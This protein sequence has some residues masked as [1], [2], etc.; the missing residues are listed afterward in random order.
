MRRISL[1][2]LFFA[3]VAVI[4]ASLVVSLVAQPNYPDAFYHFNAANRLVSG[5]GLTDTYLWTYLAAPENLPAPSHLYWMPLTSLTAAVGMWLFNAPGNYAAAQ[6]PLT[7]MLIGIIYVGYWLGQKLG[8]TRRHAWVAGLLTLF[9]GFFVRFWG[10]T[11][12]FAPYALIGSLCLVAISLGQST[13]RKWLWFGI[14]GALAGLGHL[15]RVDGLLLLLVGGVVVLWPDS[16]SSWRERIIT[17]IIMTLA[18]LVVMSPWFIRNLNAIGSPLPVGG[19]QSLWYTSYNNLF[20]YP[21]DSSLQTA[22]EAGIGVFLAARWQAFVNNLGTFV[23]VEGLVAMTPLMLIGLWQRRDSGFLRGFWL[24]G[25][26]LHLAM[27]LVFPFAGYRGGLMHSAAALIPWWAALG[28]VGL[29]DVIDW[30]AARRRR[31]KAGTAKLIFSAALVLLG[32]ALT[33]SIST[34]GQVKA[35][36]PRLYTE[37]AAKVPSDARVMINDPAQLYYF[38][39][40]G[41]VVLPN[42]TPDVIPEIARRYQVDYLVIEIIYLSGKPVLAVPDG[43]L[44]NLDYPPDFLAPISLDYP[45]ARLYAIHH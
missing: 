3:I 20:D 4:G 9:S 36:V 2:K 12:T 34:G 8:G 39:G 35:S 14:V 23:A 19:T 37:L 44:F 18:Y 7:L 26:G 32:I 40:L 27:T 42:E 10:A 33:I 43:L 29:D 16:Q 31:W 5:Q 21:P 24:Y 38:T 22:L 15:T 45:N 41:G 17:L 25:L 13:P 6:I 30:V 28:I 1:E 11:D